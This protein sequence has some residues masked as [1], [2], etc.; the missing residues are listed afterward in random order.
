MEKVEGVRGELA[1][2]GTNL[3]DRV[4]DT[5]A[6]SGFLWIGELKA[7]RLANGEMSA[8]SIGAT[9]THVSR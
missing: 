7:G 9:K 2:L 6:H 8:L 4:L 1:E 3:I 5:A